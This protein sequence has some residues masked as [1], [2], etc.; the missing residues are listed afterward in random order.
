MMAMPYFMSD[1]SWYTTNE[2][3]EY[4]LTDKAPKE[5]IEDYTKRKEAYIKKISSMS[6]EDMLDI[7]EDD[8]WL[9]FPMEDEADY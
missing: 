1:E 9:I 2:D 5:A 6:L 4:L 7:A 8:D 3:G